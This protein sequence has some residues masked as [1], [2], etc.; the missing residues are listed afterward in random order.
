MNNLTVDRHYPRQGH[1]RHRRRR[2]PRDDTGTLTLAGGT[3]DVSGTSTPTDV[4]GTGTG[5]ST[6]T[7]QAPLTAASHYNQLS[8][9]GSI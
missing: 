8:L 2:D 1:E 6:V 4:S 7:F 5:G 3:I 9:S